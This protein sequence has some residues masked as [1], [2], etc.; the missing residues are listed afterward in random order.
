MIL[1]VSRRTDV[2]AFFSA[3][4]MNR[5][6]A[7]WCE[8]ENPRRPG[9]VSRL[10]LT[11]QAVAAIVFWTRDPAPML[12]LLPEMER[13]GFA[14]HCWLVTLTDY[15]RA[16]EPGAPP[17]SAA[18]GS[19]R[20]LARRIGADRIAWRYDPIILSR[21]MDAVYHWT[22]FRAL[23]AEMEGS[24]RRVIV[25][26]YDSYRHAV[27]GI[28]R[29]L[30][31][32]GDRLVDEQLKAPALADLLSELRALASQSG[33]EMQSCAESDEVVRAAGIAPGA[34]VDAAWLR[35]I[36]KLEARGGKDPGQRPACLCA[37]ARDIGAPDT[38]PRGC[39]YCYATRRPDQARSAYARHDPAAASLRQPLR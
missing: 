35:R 19:I 1:S 15:P 38:C 7:G 34:C 10:E 6:R 29:A 30:D 28:D 25:S 22:R 16:W 20:E 31:Q 27:P 9:Q 14:N 3:W 5:L 39:V 33:M 2:P 8:V 24:T 36:F 21:R 18:V 13:L 37:V 32:T 17:L 12:P 26:I 23:C 4:F 11:P